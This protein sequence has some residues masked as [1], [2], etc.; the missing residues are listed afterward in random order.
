LVHHPRSRHRTSRKAQ[1]P[2]SAQK[3]IQK[4]RGNVHRFRPTARPTP[5]SRTAHT[6]EARTKSFERRG[7]CFLRETAAWRTHEDR[8]RACENVPVEQTR[9]G[10]TSS[11]SAKYTSNQSKTENRTCLMD[12]FPLGRWVG[13]Q[14]VVSVLRPRKPHHLVFSDSPAS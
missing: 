14:L 7:F 10:K 13:V 12:P 5:P 8:E 11:V 1:V 4:V 2:S 6:E 3:S 9:H